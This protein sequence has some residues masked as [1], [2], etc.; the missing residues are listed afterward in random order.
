M[1]P[2][3]K[4]WRDCTVT[5]GLC[6]ALE[7]SLMNMS[8]KSRRFSA[9]LMECTEEN[10]TTRQITKWVFATYPDERQVKQSNSRL[11]SVN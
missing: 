6:A 11:T 2:P 5:P 10:F 9:F 8:E 4:D 7:H 1:M 3:E